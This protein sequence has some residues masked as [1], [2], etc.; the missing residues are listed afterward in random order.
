MEQAQTS[1]DPNSRAR[2]PAKQCRS[3]Y[4]LGGGSSPFGTA[5]TTT[6]HGAGVGNIVAYHQNNNNNLDESQNKTRRV[7]MDL[8]SDEELF[9]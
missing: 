6:C 3:P 2:R 7:T 8:A 9:V 5:V 1:S 4:L